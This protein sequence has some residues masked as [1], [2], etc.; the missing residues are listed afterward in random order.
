MHAFV[1][2]PLSGGGCGL[3]AAFSLWAPPLAAARDHA[4][5]D[6]TLPRK[7]SA[8]PSPR[9]YTLVERTVESGV[10]YGY[11][12]AYKHTSDPDAEAVIEQ[13]IQAVMAQFDE[14][15]VFPE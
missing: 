4:S 11:H 5:G 3:G 14:D 10:R 13:I 2:H 1:S 12:R 6:T 9:L 7:R 15:F 8:L